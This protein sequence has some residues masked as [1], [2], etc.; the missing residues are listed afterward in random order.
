MSRTNH[1]EYTKERKRPSSHVLQSK[2]T[3]KRIQPC[4][5]ALREK[6]QNHCSRVPWSAEA[7]LA[8]LTGTSRAWTRKQAC[9]NETLQCKSSMHWT[10]S[11]ENQEAM[12]GLWIRKNKQLLQK[13]LQHL[14]SSAKRVG[15]AHIM[16]LISHIWDTTHPVFLEPPL[17]PCNVA[18]K[19][20]LHSSGYN[21]IKSATLLGGKGVINRTKAFFPDFIVWYA[22]F[23]EKYLKC[24]NDFA[25]DCR[26]YVV[27]TQSGNPIRRNRRHL[28]SLP[29]TVQQELPQKEE[30]TLSSLP[31]KQ[32]GSPVNKT[33][34]N[35]VKTESTR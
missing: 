3:G 28:V 27:V 9:P 32:D 18:K 2:P 14:Q 10:P 34:T 33:P 16:V 23:E 1:K 15:T 26:S 21:Y 30:T 29:Q 35:A 25:P 13:E 12:C 17:P 5:N 20:L 22:N 7:F 8:W 11:P 6:N 19:D 24:S 4:W 31:S